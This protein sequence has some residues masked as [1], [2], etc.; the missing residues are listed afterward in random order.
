[1][2]QR[3]E[4]QEVLPPVRIFPALPTESA[5]RKLPY[6][7]AWPAAPQIHGPPAAYEG[8]EE[9]P[10]REKPRRVIGQM[11][12]DYGVSVETVLTWLH[13]GMPYLEEGDWHTGDG[14]VLRPAWVFDWI[15]ALTC[16]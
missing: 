4:V 8:W 5:V 1:M 7:P 9:L 10:L 16:L 12:A 15:M 13:A 3:Q 11:A 2:R 6:R 14:F